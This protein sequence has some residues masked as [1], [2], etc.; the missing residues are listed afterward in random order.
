MNLFNQKMLKITSLL[1]FSM[2]FFKAKADDGYRLWLKYDVLKNTSQKAEY[3]RFTNFVDNQFGE[4]VIVNTAKKELKNG[5]A[6]MLGIALQ[7]SSKKVGGIVL[8]K[9]L[10]IAKEG[11]KIQIPTCDQLEKLKKLNQNDDKNQ[12]EQ[13]DDKIQPTKKQKALT[14]VQTAETRL[15]TK[16]NINYKP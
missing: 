3:K 16:A 2:L 11:Y 5:L 13:I 12:T 6:G 7:S 4:S 9:D 1:F 15:V 10:D 14:T 8:K